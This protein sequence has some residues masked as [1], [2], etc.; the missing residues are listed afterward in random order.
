MIVLYCE[1]YLSFELHYHTCWIPHRSSF[2]VHDFT[3]RSKLPAEYS[4][5]YCRKFYTILCLLL[6]IY[7]L[8][9]K[10]SYC[11]WCNQIFSRLSA[12]WTCCC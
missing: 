9:Q 11:M 12:R 10:L 5:Y 6:M 4:S 3:V 8:L 1:I 2:H 7:I